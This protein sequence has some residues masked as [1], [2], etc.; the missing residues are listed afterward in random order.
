MT[1]IQ[2]DADRIVPTLR[3]EAAEVVGRA[4]GELILDF[5]SVVKIDAGA[6]RAMEELA[7]LADRSS[8]R[9]ALRAVNIGIYRA[10]K[11]LNLTQKFSFLT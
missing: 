6:A 2:V 3:G 4:G 11:L 9:V 10:L 8:V 5:S 1:T 7:D